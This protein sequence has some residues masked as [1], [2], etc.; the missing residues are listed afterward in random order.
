[1]TAAKPTAADPA[2]QLREATREAHGLLRDIRTERRSLAAEHA[3]LA[4]AN[5]QLAESLQGMQQVIEGHARQAVTTALQDQLDQ[6]RTMIE[7]LAGAASTDD[8][9]DRLARTL[10]PYIREHVGIAVLEYIRTAE[11]AVNVNGQPARLEGATA[12]WLRG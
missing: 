7:A 9:Y 11:F 3:R 1:V 6:V 10:H 8:F 12:E 5:R 2:E 4:D